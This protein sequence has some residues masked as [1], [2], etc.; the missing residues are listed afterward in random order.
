VKSEGLNFFDMTMKTS[1]ESHAAG[2]GIE[3]R[4]DASQACF[5]KLFDLKANLPVSN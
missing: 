3:A 2:L 4:A 1:A 5:G